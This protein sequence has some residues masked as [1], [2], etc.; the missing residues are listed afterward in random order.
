MQAEYKEQINDLTNRLQ[1]MLFNVRHTT[2]I[3]QQEVISTQ[4]LI[5][6]ATNQ[7]Y[8]L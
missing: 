8:T 3:S 6:Q 7:L 1:Q 2:N 4:K 5:D